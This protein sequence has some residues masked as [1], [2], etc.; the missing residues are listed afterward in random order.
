MK[1]QLRTLTTLMWLSLAALHAAPAP[2]SAPLA[3]DN[4]KS[5]TSAGN[6]VNM[7]EFCNSRH[8]NYL[9]NVP[10]NR[11][12]RLPGMLVRRLKEV[13]QHSKDR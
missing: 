6:V 5:V 2:D 9:L 7:L 3:G 13:G 4:E 8:A 12:G 11:S 10:P 1:L